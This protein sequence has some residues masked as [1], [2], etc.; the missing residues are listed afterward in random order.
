M[1]NR[2]WV[3]SSST[4]VCHASTLVRCKMNIMLID[5]CAKRDDYELYY[6]YLYITMVAMLGI[7]GHEGWWRMNGRPLK[8][9]TYM[10]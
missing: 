8:S 1:E 6:T 7:P 4:L 3:T 10:E 9:I 5:K 2:V